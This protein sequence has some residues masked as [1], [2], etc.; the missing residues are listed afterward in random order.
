MVTP[1]SQAKLSRAGG[2]IYKTSTA[3]LMFVSTTVGLGDAVTKEA[4][5]W[6]ES[7][8]AIV[9]VGKIMRF[10]NDI[11]AFKVQFTHIN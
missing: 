4:L 8:T 1:E 11:A 2:F 5:E 6:A 3:H 7:S 10:M 9:A